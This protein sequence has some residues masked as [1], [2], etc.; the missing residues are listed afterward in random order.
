MITTE[1]LNHNQIN[2]NANSSPEGE[3]ASIVQQIETDMNELMIEACKGAIC[4]VSDKADE[5]LY[6]HLTKLKLR[7]NYLH[8]STFNPSQLKRKSKYFQFYQSSFSKIFKGDKITIEKNIHKREKNPSNPNNPKHDSV[9]I[10]SIFDPS[11]EIT[12]PNDPFDAQLVRFDTPIIFHEYDKYNSKIVMFVQFSFNQVPS[13]A[14]RKEQKFVDFI[15]GNI[16]ENRNID[17]TSCNHD[18]DTEQ[19]DSVNDCNHDHEIDSD[20]KVNNKADGSDSDNDGDNDDC[21]NYDEVDEEYWEEMW[22]IEARAMDSSCKY[23]IGIV[24]NSIP[25]DRFNLSCE[26]SESNEKDPTKI[27]FYGIGTFKDCIYLGG[28]R[29]GWDCAEQV[30]NAQKRHLH[31]SKS[32]HAYHESDNDNDNDEDDG[33]DVLQL[34]KFVPCIYG[35]DDESEMK[36]PTKPGI[37]KND[38]VRLEIDLATKQMVYFVHRTDEDEDEDDEDELIDMSSEGDDDDDDDDYDGHDNDHNG[39]EKNDDSSSESGVNDDDSTRLFEN[40]DFDKLKFEKIGAI[41]LGDDVDTS[42]KANQIV[43]KT[44]HPCIGLAEQGACVKVMFV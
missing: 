38:I 18:N 24:P 42:F 5:I 15:N 6:K 28:G 43:P 21:E 20:T 33:D 41:Q 44:Y 11:L 31:S 30:L 36:I 10:A 40:M 22:D 34:S 14:K 35:I 3:I 7:I 4:A 32:K 2:E 16:V 25:C 8:P 1:N 39:D 19:G 37:Y 13:F 26:E 29:K 27:A 9:S 12:Q 23:F 17:E